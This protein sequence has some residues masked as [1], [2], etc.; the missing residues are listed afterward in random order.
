MGRM[1]RCDGG[2]PCEE[3]LCSR[4]AR[5]YRLWFAG[6][7]LSFAVEPVEAHIVTILLVAVGGGLLH[8]VSVR[9]EHDR[10]RKR[11]IRCGVR[12]AIGGT[13]AAYDA[14]NDR[15]VVHVHLLVFGE[16]KHA[17]AH[18][19]WWRKKTASNGP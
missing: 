16:T 9:A 8:T 7:C 12:S 13:E 6:Q 3:I 14:P 2:A 17:I 11:L 10:L 18:S 5:P 15:W 19:G 1:L 4:C